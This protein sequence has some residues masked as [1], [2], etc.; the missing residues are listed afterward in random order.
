MEAGKAR[1]RAIKTGLLGELSVEV[2]SG[3]SGGETIIIG[4]FKA[5]RELKDGDAVKQEEAKK[6]TGRQG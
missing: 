6:E 1:F 2:T 5:L 4:P 3:L